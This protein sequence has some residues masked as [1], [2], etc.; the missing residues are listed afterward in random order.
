[1]AQDHAVLRDVEGQGIIVLGSGL[2]K[3]RNVFALLRYHPLP[4]LLGGI[5]LSN[6]PTK[7]RRILLPV[8]ANHHMKDT[9]R[10]MQPEFSGHGI[11]VIARVYPSHTA[12]PPVLL[13]LLSEYHLSLTSAT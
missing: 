5:D 3:C 8:P 12:G 11:R 9:S 10:Y 4:L 13:T 6:M 1:M 2:R 7:R